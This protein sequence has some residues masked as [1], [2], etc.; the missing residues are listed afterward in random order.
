MRKSGY[1]QTDARMTTV[2]GLPALVGSYEGNASGIG[3]VLARG[4]HVELGRETFFVGGIAPPDLFP[5]VSAD[6]DRAI[7]TF[8]EMSQAEADAVE[9]NLL[10]LYTVR[11]GDTW[12]SIAQRAGGG[13]MSAMALAVMNGHAIDAQPRPGTRVKIVVPGS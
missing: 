1:K 5:R 13:T 7:Q 2:N 8:R 12:Q 3:R 10:D 9:P 4:A 11:E 6:F